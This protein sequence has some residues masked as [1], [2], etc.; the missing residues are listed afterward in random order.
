MSGKLAVFGRGVRYRSMVS[1][2][3]V[4]AWFSACCVCCCVCACV[5]MSFC[6]CLFADPF[7]SPPVLWLSESARVC[8]CLSV[9]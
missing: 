4:C 8:P 3:R 5:C 2:L 9:R 6:L 7:A 1:L